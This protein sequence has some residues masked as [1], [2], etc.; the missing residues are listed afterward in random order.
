MFRVNSIWFCHLCACLGILLAVPG[1]GRLKENKGDAPVVREDTPKLCSDNVDND[2]NGVADCDDSNCGS[3]AVCK[4]SAMESVERPQPVQTEGA[5][6]VSKTVIDKEQPL[7]RKTGTII[8]D[9]TCTDRS[10][11]PVE[12]IER[13]KKTLNIAYTH[14]S[15]GS[16]LVSGMNALKKYPPF[17]GTY[18]WGYPATSQALT[19]LDN[20]M[21]VGM[22]DLSRGDSVDKNGDTPWVVATRDFLNSPERRNVNVVLWSWCSINNRNAKRYVDNMEK[23]IAEFPNVVFVFMTG[24]AEG[25]SESNRSQDVHSNNELIRNHVRTHGRVL[26]DFADIEAHDPDGKYYWD[27]AMRDNLS[28]SGGNWGREWI[29]ANPS[30]ELAK[31]TTGRGV[32][33]YEGIRDCAHSNNPQEANINCVL[34]GIAAWWMFARIAGWEGANE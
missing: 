15:H 6:I 34:K 9:H 10:K 22:S 5:G 26:F 32:A 31:L 3:L 29:E 18:S 25:Q 24:H 27:R 28:Y 4:S 23:L 17:G 11:I 1:C 20:G 21:A 33:G 7:N 13:A 16:Q 12:A 2:W 19:M 14:T 8:I 30:S